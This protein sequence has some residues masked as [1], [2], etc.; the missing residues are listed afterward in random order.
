MARL[1]RTKSGIIQ[2]AAL[3]IARERERLEN[4]DRTSVDE[5]KTKIWLVL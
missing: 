2:F 3:P 4:R 5:T 1:G